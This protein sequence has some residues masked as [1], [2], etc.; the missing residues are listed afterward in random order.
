MVLCAR[1]VLTETMNGE[2]TMRRVRVWIR[3]QRI[4]YLRVE[5]ER[6]L[7]RFA[8]RLARSLQACERGLT[9]TREQ[10]Q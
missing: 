3:A 10:S 8:M 6:R 4:H 7:A 9:Q 5:R 1:S 2:G